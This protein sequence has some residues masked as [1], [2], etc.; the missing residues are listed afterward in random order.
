MK[1]V[2]GL[3]FVIGA[4]IAGLMSLIFSGSIAERV[5][6]HWGFNGQPDRYGSRWEAL[7]FVPIMLLVMSVVFGLVGLVSGNRLKINATK[8]INIV[9][10]AVVLFMLVIHKLL[11]S[12]DHAAIPNL[13]PFLLSGLLVVLGF[14]M[15]GVEPNP[16]IGIRV[17]WTMNSPMVWRLTHDRASRLWMFAGAVGLIFSLAGG[18]TLAP[19]IIFVFSILYPLFDSYR[20]SKTV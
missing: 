7:L 18:N 14:A 2:A 13:I 4:A 12:Q 1:Y 20:I 5:P 9:A 16:F 11:L 19:I 17:P 10:A 15:K 8:G 6:M 3:I